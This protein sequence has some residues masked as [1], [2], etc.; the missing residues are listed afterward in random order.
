MQCTVKYCLWLVLVLVGFQPLLAQEGGGPEG[1]P[2]KEKEK[3][4]K[5]LTA[6]EY[7]VPAGESP[8]IVRN[9][10]IV[11]NRKT[12]PSIILRELSFKSGDAFLLQ[13]LVKKFELARQQLMNLA[14]FHEVTVALKSFD[15]YNVDVLVQVRER[16]YLFPVPYFRPVDRNLNQWIVEQK[17]SLNRVDYGL[18]LLYNNATG[19]NDKLRFTVV[20]GYSRQLLLNY[21]RPYIDKGMKWG[22]SFGV[23]LG[24]NREMNYNTVDDK[25][26]F[27]KDE[28]Y[29]RNFARGY[30]EVSYRK[31]IRTRH[32]LGL[33]YGMEE[34]ADTIVKL[35]PNYF[36]G[37]RNR[38]VFPE[39]YYYF[40][41]FNLDYIPYPTKGYAGEVAFSKKGI[42]SSF[43][44]WQLG[45][46]G[47]ANWPL[48]KKSFFS[49]N[50]FGTVKLPFKQPYYNRRLLGYSDIFMQGYEYYVVDGVAGGYLK[51]SL[52]K[53]LLNFNFNFKGTK[54]VA[55]L[56]IPVNIYG[57]IYGNTGYIYDP[58]PGEN[59]LGNRMLFS[60]GIGI[61]IVTIYDFVF[62]LDWS[63]NQLG[64]NALYFHRRSIF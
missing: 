13:D 1:K 61:D 57:R 48:G 34:V 21:D 29:L 5:N 36:P 44:S 58:N 25:Q 15:G 43:N 16:W 12:H 40:N 10:V 17:A 28:S 23:S 42:F 59:F 26:V 62:K 38:I 4:E 51:A 45:L 46:K 31:A 11:G 22:L 50:A 37:G 64:Q 49:M 39:L 41:Y 56:R 55:P 63:F 20:S 24:R 35:N 6:E 3:Q 47:S 14:L 19:R 27:L 8:F 18:K 53:R 9:I 33:S 2:K 52:T 54:K 7:V 32:R 30:V 60:S